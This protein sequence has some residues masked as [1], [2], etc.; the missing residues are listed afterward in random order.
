MLCI[1]FSQYPGEMSRLAC[2]AVAIARSNAVPFY[3]LAT[4]SG[5]VTQRICTFTKVQQAIIK[6]SGVP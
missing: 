2:L 6:Q 4:N 1:V 3:T 5:L